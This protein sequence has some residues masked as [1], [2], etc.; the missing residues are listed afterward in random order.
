MKRLLVNVEGQ[1]EEQFVNEILRQH[2]GNHGYS[3]VAARLLGSRRER[4]FRGGVRP[5]AAVK[6]EVEKQ[7]NED[8]HVLCSLLVDFYALPTDWPARQAAAAMSSS[9]KGT[10]VA[11]SLR[12]DLDPDLQRRFIPCVLVHEFETFIFADVTAATLAWGLERHREAL[13]AIRDGFAG[14]EDIND[15]PQTAP[16]KRVL[17]VIPTYEKPLM[18]SLAAIQI[19]L[20]TLRTECPTF[21]AWVD[22][23]EAAGATQPAM[24]TPRNTT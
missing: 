15:S 2:L 24:T 12:A 21:G 7:L 18:G 9:Q 16:S 10:H 20:Q 8:R 14:A 22:A 17:G 11:A 5:W 19:G 4:A 23:L 1:T 6:R 3:S 13:Q